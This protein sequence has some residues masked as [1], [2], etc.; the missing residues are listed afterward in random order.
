MDVGEMFPVAREQGKWSWSTGLL[1]ESVSLSQLSGCLT[2]PVS[3]MGHVG[4]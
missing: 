4:S 1:E 2:P 3:G